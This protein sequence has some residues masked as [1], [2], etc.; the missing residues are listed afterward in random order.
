MKRG[1]LLI[2][3]FLL[4]GA[5]LNV[6][7]AW[8]Y[9]C[10]LSNQAE[11]KEFDLD[12]ATAIWMEFTGRPPEES[13]FESQIAIDLSSSLI[14]MRHVEPPSNSPYE[15]ELLWIF[16]FGFPFR[17]I[18]Y[19]THTTSDGFRDTNVHDGVM[20]FPILRLGPIQLLGR[21]AFPYHIRPIGFILDTIFWAG[22]AWGVSLL[23]RT[24]RRRARLDA[25]RCP[26]CRY[27]LRGAIETGADITCAECGEIIPVA[28]LARPKRIIRPWMLPL[29]IGPLLL[30][31][32]QF[33][34]LMDW[35]WVRFHFLWIDTP[36]SPLAIGSMLVIAITLGGLA[37]AAYRDRSRVHRIML[38]AVFSLLLSISGYLSLFIFFARLRAI[39]P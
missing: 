2:T 31:G 9:S 7:V 27:D 5:M 29:L 6:I 1:M 3:V 20:T 22:V 17:S 25:K 18:E 13:L 26:R 16:R 36:T 33:F 32:L 39:W 10:Y 4:L 12:K 24:H 30:V 21:C 14:V 37:L 23:N 15:I 38:M 19:T 8:R 11:L 35:G 28:L 34:G